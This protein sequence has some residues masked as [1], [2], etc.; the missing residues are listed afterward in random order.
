M[1]AIIQRVSEA[2]VVVENKV[3][4]QIEQ[5]I[6]VLLGVEKLDNEQ[7]ADKLLHKICGYRIFNDDQGPWVD[8]E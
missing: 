3:I 2:K 1:Q 7:V 4:G 6:L 8:S 5:G